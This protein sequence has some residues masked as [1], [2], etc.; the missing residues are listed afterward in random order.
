MLLLF[1]VC[2]I[3]FSYTH[4]AYSQSSEE[5]SHQPLNVVSD[6]MTAQQDTSMIEFSGNVKAEMEDST[7]FADSIKI[8]FTRSQKGK[9]NS[10]PDS[11]DRIICSG[12]VKYIG[13]GRSALADKAVFTT[14]DGILVLTGKSPKL[15]TDSGFVTG[16]KI[17]VFRKEN[18]V[19]I[20]SSSSKRV[21]AQFNP[22]KK[23]TKKSV[24]KQSVKNKK[25]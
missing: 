11:V 9:E 25:Q 8:Y 23:I 7:L 22:E 20:E 1:L 24:K 16:K 5:L 21:E 13:G 10:E 19:T 12:N 18:K 15:I 2:C 17:T 6:T 14:I 4:T 3:L